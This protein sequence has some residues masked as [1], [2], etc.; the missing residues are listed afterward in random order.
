[1]PCPDV[2]VIWKRPRAPVSLPA[3]GSPADS[4]AAI[5]LSHEARTVSFRATA[6]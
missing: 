2:V 3:E 5:A 4:V 6:R 1:M